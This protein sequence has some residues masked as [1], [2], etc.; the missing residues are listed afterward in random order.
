[1]IQ[2]QSSFF[3]GCSNSQIVSVQHMAEAIN[4]DSKVRSRKYSILERIIFKITSL[5]VVKVQTNIRPLNTL[6]NLTLSNSAFLCW[7]K[8]SIS[9][10]VIFSLSPR[11]Q[12]K[13]AASCVI[14][15]IVCP[16]SSREQ[17]EHKGSTC[18]EWIRR[19]S[20]SNDGI[21][22]R[23]SDLRRRQRHTNIC[24]DSGLLSENT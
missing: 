12:Q 15:A 24:A 4:G 20:N 6:A 9:E 2:L 14:C 3:L 17:K 21:S 11:I 10:K 22:R 1:M 16:N 5:G 23:G 7:Q 13:I 18:S 8:I 19:N